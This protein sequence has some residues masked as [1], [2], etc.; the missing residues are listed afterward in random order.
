MVWYDA[1]HADELHVYMQALLPNGNY[2][3]CQ[4][5]IVYLTTIIQVS[6]VTI[7]PYS[8]ILL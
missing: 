6:Y 8:F 5:M 4:F 3:T 7:L 1:F 2:L